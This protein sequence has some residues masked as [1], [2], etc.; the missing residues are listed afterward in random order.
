MRLEIIVN[1]H[2]HF[3]PAMISLHFD[4]QPQ[5]KYELFQIY[6]TSIGHSNFITRTVTKVPVFSDLRQLSELCRARPAFTILFSNT[7][8]SR[9]LETNRF[10]IS[11][12]YWRHSVSQG[13][14]LDVTVISKNQKYSN[15]SLYS[16]HMNQRTMLIFL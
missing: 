1:F 9:T 6:F 15:F 3:P 13:N 11:V 12:K 4:L 7:A 16:T 8:F 2:D 14:Q 5:L 10:P